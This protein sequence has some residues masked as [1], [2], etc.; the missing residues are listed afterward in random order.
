MKVKV[1]DVIDDVDIINNTTPNVK[2]E[3]NTTPSPSSEIDLL[4]TNTTI[5]IFNTFIKL[6][7][8]VDTLFL[9]RNPDHKNPT[10]LG[11]KK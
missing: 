3:T 4:I 1:R 10:S 9:P 5:D 6:D 8:Y 7:E 11:N 2:Y